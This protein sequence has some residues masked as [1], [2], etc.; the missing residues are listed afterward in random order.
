MRDLAVIIP[1]YNE[2]EIIDVVIRDWTKILSNL[3]IDF[4]IFAY[5]DGSKD[6]SLEVLNQEAKE[7]THLTVVDKANSGHGPTILRGYKDHLN[8]YE[9]IFQV[10]SDNEMPAS[11]FEELWK[12]RDKYDF[13]IGYREGRSSNIFRKMLS[14][15]SQLAVGIFFGTNISDVNSPYRRMRSKFVKQHIKFIDD[16]TFAPNVIISG[17]A[18]QNDARI[19]TTN[20]PCTFRQ[21]GTVSLNQSKLIGI[22]WKCFLQTLKFRIR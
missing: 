11:N 1:V 4:T 7:N 12:N 8:E 20:V 18:S 9:W 10:D 21:T 2:D 19:F 15:F 6:T 3:G 13:L 5:N 17:I 16:D 14:W 22:A